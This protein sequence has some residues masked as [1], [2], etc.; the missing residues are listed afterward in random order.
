MNYRYYNAARY[1]TVAADGDADDHGAR[2]FLPISFPV[3]L[4]VRR[5]LPLRS[6]PSTSSARTARGRSPVSPLLR[7]RP[8]HAR[9]RDRSVRAIDVLKAACVSVS[10]TG[11]GGRQCLHDG[12]KSLPQQSPA[13]LRRRLTGR[14]APLLP[15]DAAPQQQSAVRPSRRHGTVCHQ[16]PVTSP[17]AANEV[18]SVETESWRKGQPAMADPH[19]QLISKIC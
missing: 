17:V 19:E 4:A 6:N 1:S 3:E 16:H 18:E 10:R 15:R 14:A 2:R 7:G 9:F 8:P 11:S 13:E 5:A 12:T